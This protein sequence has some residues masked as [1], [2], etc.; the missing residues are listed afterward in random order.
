VSLNHFS[1][2]SGYYRR[3]LPSLLTTSFLISEIGRQPW[4][5]L[6]VLG[7]NGP[8]STNGRTSTFCP[9]STLTV[10]IICRWSDCNSLFNSPEEFRDHCMGTLSVHRYP[11][12]KK[13]QTMCFYCGE[14]VSAIW[15]HVTEVHLKIARSR[16][17]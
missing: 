14:I 12:G 1:N 2:S 3:A 10:Q 11:L 7:Q 16:R 17:N 8:A 15:C 13:I 5:L 9:S 4:I 6:K